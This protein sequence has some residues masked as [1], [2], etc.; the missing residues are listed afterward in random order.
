M[1]G[2]MEVGAIA[3]PLVAV[4]IVT[5]ASATTVTG[6]SIDVTGFT[7]RAL[8]MATTTTFSAGLSTFEVQEANETGFTT[9]VAVINTSAVG[10]TTETAT[11]GTAVTGVNTKF[12]S[13]NLDGKKK[14][15]RVNVITSGTVTSGQATAFIAM[16]GGNYNLSGGTF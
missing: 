7:G 11:F 15:I 12:R 6:T 10:G 1:P 4:P 9:G 3:K 14:F 5:I 16:G 8:I 2:V 13:L